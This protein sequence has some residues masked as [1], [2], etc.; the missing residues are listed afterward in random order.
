MSVCPSRPFSFFLSETWP[1]ALCGIIIMRAGWFPL[2][3]SL[4][5]L[6][7]GLGVELAVRKSNSG[8]L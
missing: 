2:L 5:F 8:A 3:L 4:S 6:S 7:L 1:G